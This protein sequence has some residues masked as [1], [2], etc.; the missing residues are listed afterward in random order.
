MSF[1][2]AF[3]MQESFVSAQTP[4]STPFQASSLK[5]IGTGFFNPHTG[6][7]FDKESGELIRQVTDQG[8]IDFI[9]G[10]A[11]TTGGETYKALGILDTGLVKGTVGAHLAQGL[12]WAG[13]VYLGAKAIGGA[14]GLDKNNANALAIAG[15]AGVITFKALT[16]LQKKGL[17][18]GILGKGLFANPII[19]AIGVAVA[20]F[21]F[22]YKK[23]SKKIVTFQCLPFEPPL[24]G[25]K[26]EACNA[27]PFRPCSE[28]RCKSLGQA[29]QI[30][31]AGTDK[32]QCAWINPKD[33]TS[34]TITPWTEALKPRTSKYI[35]DTSI[36]PPA[37]GVKIVSG[38][39]GCLQAFTPLEFGITTNE[40]AQCKIDY[41]HTAKFDDMQYY[42]GENNYYSY[43]HTQKMR[44]PGPD[45][46]TDAESPLL[47][48]DGTFSLYVR[49]RDGNGNENVD[50]YAMSFCVDKGPDTTPPIIEKTSI[51]SGSFVQFN[52]DKIPI[53]VYVNEP[54]ECKWSKQD[55][56]Y[57]DMEN[58]MQCNTDSFQINSDLL[59]TCSGELTG[60]QNGA[61]NKFYFRCKDQPG[62]PDNERN[63]NA[64]SYA[65]TLKGSKSELNI[66]STAPNGTI[67]SS[68]SSVDLN[69]EAETSNGAEEG[70][71]IC[72][73]SNSENLD[74]FIQMFNSN[75]FKHSQQLSLGAGD[76]KYYIR[77]IDSGGN[78]AQDSVQ[79]KVVID[80]TAPKI[81]RIYREGVDALKLV[82]D[83]ESECAY[84]LNSCNFVFDEGIK[85]IYNPP[86][87][88]NIMFAEWK[89][90]AIYYIKCRDDYGNEPSSNT[91]S[92]I[93]S[94]IQ[95]SKNG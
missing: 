55:K 54:S 18:Q 32:E 26:C 38:S 44:L 87:E 94:A 31:N 84:S 92:I 14:L 6:Q 41:N 16:I 74:S 63:V 40:P 37:L 65:L 23:E 17:A 33:V 2:L 89:P 19:P 58:S 8:E 22:L 81:T 20:V 67:F 90:N 10:A 61:D 29:C 48:N 85:F 1:A 75:S 79:F 24:G 15:V 13:V 27:D 35:T 51:T 80:K 36:R 72:Y 82:T 3:I 62:K 5:D 59:F 73:F 11:A 83:E 42:F 30:L 53:Q 28:Y 39:Q 68:T 70:K 57:N 93:A 64:Q 21:I 76:Y 49:C 46:L 95:L 91:C 56:A 88:R 47:K 45:A 69:L 9:G 52:A 34:P 78:T 43:N 86:S 60:V 71:A 7:I 25:S 77:C 66:I 12:V 4:V 50:E